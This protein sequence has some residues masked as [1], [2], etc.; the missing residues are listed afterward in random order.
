MR[1]SNGPAA[2]RVAQPPVSMLDGGF[3]VW[4]HSDTERWVPRGVETCQ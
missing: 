3:R 2:I 1:S 4:S